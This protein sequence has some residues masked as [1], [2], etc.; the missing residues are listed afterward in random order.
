METHKRQRLEA[1]GWQVGE[2][3]DFLGLT[4][5]EAEVVEIK[6]ALSG[7]LKKTR[8]DKHLSQQAL[9][10]QANS[11]QSRVAKMEAGEQS[12]SMD[13][14]VRTLL[15]AGATREEVGRAIAGS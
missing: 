5:A 4:P 15:Q 10:Q 12:V 6:L 13:L 2:A 7:L 8:Q 3:S 9:A 14:L 1:A 11:S